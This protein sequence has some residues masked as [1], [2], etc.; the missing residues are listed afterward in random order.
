MHSVRERGMRKTSASMVG[1]GVCGLLAILLWSEASWA[2]PKK[3]TFLLCKCT[4]RADDV[5][6]KHPLRQYRW[7][8]VHDVA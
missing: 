7:R 5:L 4:C 2:K 8:L 1:L 3:S 6:G